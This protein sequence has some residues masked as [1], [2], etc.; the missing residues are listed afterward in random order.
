MHR[1]I[2]SL[3]CKWDGPGSPARCGL[4]HKYGLGNPWGF[5]WAVKG[6]AKDGKA[7]LAVPAYLHVQPWRR[8]PDTRSGE[9]PTGLK[10]TLTA[11]GLTPG[12]T[13][14]IWRWD[15]VATA[16]TYDP[17]YQKATFVAANAT[18]VYADDKSF[19]SDGAT[20]YR[21]IRSE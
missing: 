2:S 5:G 17:Q 10:G 3:P 9:Q 12:A 11:T 13:Y 21:V 14:S 4:L 18:H 7:A 1:K 8:E 15:A 19:P 6:F 20:Y 16:F